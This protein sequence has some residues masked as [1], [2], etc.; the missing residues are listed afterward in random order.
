[1]TCCR[2][3]LFQSWEVMH[4]L[5]LHC[6]DQWPEIRVAA[7]LALQQFLRSEEGRTKQST[8]WLA[9]ILWLEH[10]WVCV[11]WF[12]L[13]GWLLVWWLNKWCAWFVFDVLIFRRAPLS[14]SVKSIQGNCWPSQMWDGMMWRNRSWRKLWPARFSSSC[15][16][17]PNIAP[18]CQR[19]RHRQDHGQPCSSVVHTVFW[20]VLNH[21]FMRKM[22][23]YIYYGCIYLCTSL[24]IYIYVYF[25]YRYHMHVCG[26]IYIYID[27]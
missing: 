7:D 16:A 12:V 1:M 5:F 3:S 21:T 18:P 15:L 23:I 17:I 8:P 19:K 11:G 4:R 6:C 27:I 13:I 14:R 26:H 22:C 20:A 24:S 25:W 10:W 9:Y 2:S